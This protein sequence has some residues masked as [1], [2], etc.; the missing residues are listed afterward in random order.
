MTKAIRTGDRVQ[1]GAVR[2]V[3]L[4]YQGRTGTVVG[5]GDRNRF[6]VDF[7]ARRANPLEVAGRFLRVTA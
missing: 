5:F 3:P 1:V 2:N 7:G 4:R 6:L